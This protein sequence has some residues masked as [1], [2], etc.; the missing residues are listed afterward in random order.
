VSRPPDPLP[1]ALAR[2][3]L[4]ADALAALGLRGQV[5]G[6]GIAPLLPGARIAGRALTAATPPAA[7]V[8]PE[9]YAGLLALLVA[10]RPGDV[11]VLATGRSDAAAVW[12]E[13]TSSSCVARGT[14]GLV[15]DGRCRDA[16]QVRE[17]GF[18]AFCRGTSP[19]DMGGRLD[20]GP[21]GVPV[22]I[23][24]VPDAPGGQLAARRRPRAAAAR[25]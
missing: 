6:P 15:T 24:G 1:A 4:L 2:S 23:D 8:A 18:P 9:P 11:V 25:V 21:H 20:V 12:G 13:L 3:S 10:V 7:E 19:R 22:T 16:E 17:P 5:L 14:A